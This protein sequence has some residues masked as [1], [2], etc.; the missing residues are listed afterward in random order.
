MEH[1]VNKY[2]AMSTGRAVPSPTATAARCVGA[3]RATAGRLPGACGGVRRTGN[4]PIGNLGVL[5]ARRAAAYPGG[6]PSVASRLPLRR[7]TTVL[8]GRPESATTWP[9]ARLSSDSWYGLRR[10]KNSASASAS[11]SL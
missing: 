5:P 10:T 4:E 6:V 11:A 1:F 2:P 8:G 3:V 9:T 7:G